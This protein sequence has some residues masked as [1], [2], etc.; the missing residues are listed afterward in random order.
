MGWT[1]RNHWYLL[2]LVHPG[3]VSST[4]SSMFGP[5]ATIS[6]GVVESIA[7]FIC[8]VVGADWACL[9]ISRCHKWV[10]GVQ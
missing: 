4:D 2:A 7:A 6:V 8:L 5:N 3:A 10:L 9:E 1:G